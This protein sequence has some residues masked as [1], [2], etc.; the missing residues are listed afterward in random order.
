MKNKN[1]NRQIFIVVFFLFLSVFIFISYD[2]STRTTAPWNKKKKVELALP[3]AL[4]GSDSLN[5]DSLLRDL[6]KVDSS[7]QKK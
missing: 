2:M 5:L 1:R 3:G 7:Q 4:P 6:E